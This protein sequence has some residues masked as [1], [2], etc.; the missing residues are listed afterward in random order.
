[1][2]Q[3]HSPLRRGLKL[4]LGS[5]RHPHP[6]SVSAALPA[7][8]DAVFSA[9]NPV[10]TCR[11]LKVENV[12]S[13]L[14]KALKDK[15]M[16]AMKAAYRL[17][18]KGA[19]AKLKQQA[20]WLQSQHPSA[21]ASRLEGREETFT[22]SRIGLSP[23][24]RRCL[25]TTNIVESPTAGVISSMVATRCTS[26]RAPRTSWEAPPPGGRRLRTRRVTRWKDGAM[27]LRRAA[28]ALLATEKQ[29]RR[30]IGYQELWTLK[31]ARDET[32]A[33]DRIAAA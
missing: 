28:T 31:A 6:P 24:R 13:Y 23:K 9:S 33:A 5:P 3:P 8:T 14:P 21:A 27:V 4:G 10:Q 30:I 18:A 17:D 29:F 22:I 1:M 12:V 16:T 19:M 7:G 15:L 11:D 2:S 20:L 32:A 26:R 25:G